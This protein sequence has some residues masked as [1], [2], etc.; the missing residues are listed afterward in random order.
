MYTLVSTVKRLE[1]QITQKFSVGSNQKG[2]N[3]KGLKQE[4][5]KIQM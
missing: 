4:H 1:S 3:Q 5:Q 2:S